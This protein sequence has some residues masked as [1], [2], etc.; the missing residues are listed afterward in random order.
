MLRRKIIYL[1][2]LI[3]LGFLSILYD[4]YVMSLIF[5]VALLFP[6]V[7][8]AIAW[9][10]RSK[11][12]VSVA[13]ASKIEKKNKEIE[14]EILIKN[15]TIFPVARLV[16]K[17]K[18]GHHYEEATKKENLTSFVDASNEQKLTVHFSSMYCGNITFAVE[19]IRL[20]DYLNIFSFKKQISKELT[21]SIIPEFYI[22][23]G[24]LVWENPNVL[25][26]SDIYSTIKS[27]DDSSE[28]FSIHEYKEGDR[29]NHIHWKLSLKEDALMVKEFGLPIDCSVV[30]LLEL[31]ANNK[32]TLKEVDAALQAVLSLSFSM[33]LSKQ[34]HFIAWYD[35]Y[36][37]ICKR[38]KIEKE[39][40]LYET[41]SYIF[42]SKLYVFSDA[43]VRFHA[44]EFEKE[45]YTN[46]FY[47]TPVLT[48]IALQELEACKRNAWCHIIAISKE[49]QLTESVEHNWITSTGFN[50]I[51]PDELFHS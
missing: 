35:N 36:D 28:I 32:N 14:V 24:K 26:Q 10:V 20:Y 38:S 9:Y 5:L 41:F 34:Q 46:I 11:L 7:L 22:I 8:A 48:E 19:T 30:I 16:V 27:G 23:E 47:V 43:V 44:A 42:Q 50:F 18:Y 25:L 17:T 39:E 12:Q 2:L 33:I 45:G 40:D 49:S 4:S 29:M 6:V 3:I 13:S 1:L 51:N 31:C 15:P 21:I 37:G